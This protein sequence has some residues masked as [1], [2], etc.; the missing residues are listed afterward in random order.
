VEPYFVTLKA[1][2]DAEGLGHKRMQGIE[3]EL[4]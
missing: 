2:V 1:R 3:V 4:S